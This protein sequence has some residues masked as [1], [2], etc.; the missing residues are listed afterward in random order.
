MPFSFF[1]QRPQSRP[2]EQPDAA[3]KS[4][5]AFEESLQK[6]RSPEQLTRAMRGMERHRTELTERHID[7]IQQRL[8]LLSGSVR[9]TAIEEAERKL[10]E[11]RGH[12]TGAATNA[13]TSNE[14]LPNNTNLGTRIGMG[15]GATVL[16]WF[17][18]RAIRRDG[19][20]GGI[21][22]LFSRNARR[23]TNTVTGSINFARR[24]PIMTALLAGMGVGATVQIREYMNANS[25]ALIREIETSAREQGIDPQRHAETT[26]ERLGNFVRTVGSRTVDTLIQGILSVFGGT[27]DP[28]TGAIHLPHSTLRPPIIIA[29][30][31][32]VRRQGGPAWWRATFGKLGGFLVEP[33]ANAIL[34]E[35]RVAGTMATGQTLGLANEANAL[36]REMNSGASASR[37]VDIEKRLREIHRTLHADGRLGVHPGERFEYGNRNLPQRLEQITA[38]AERLH[39]KEHSDFNRHRH[40]IEQFLRT[41]ENNIRNGNTDGGSVHKYKEAKLGELDTKVKAYEQMLK[42]RKIAVGEEFRRAIEFHAEGRMDR[43]GGGKL[44]SL[45]K[46]M[47]NLGYSFTKLPGA[48][49]VWKGLVGY[50]FLPLGLEAASYFSNKLEGDHRR[51][52]LERKREEGQRLTAA[53]EQELHRLQNQGVTLVKDAAQVGGGFIPVVGEA[54]DFYGAFSGKDLNGRTLSTEARVTMGIMGGLGAAS[55][56]LA[57]FTG[58]LSVVGFRGLRAAIG[59]R[60]AV[61]AVGAVKQVERLRAISTVT[62]TQRTAQS[63]RNLIF[64]A[65]R[66]MQV[67]TYGLLGVQMYSGAVNLLETGSERFVAARERFAGAVE[68][69]TDQI[70]NRIPGRAPR[71]QAPSESGEN[72]SA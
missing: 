46:R 24:N 65:Q 72:E 11:L 19:L 5:K 49:L 4:L 30:Q 18:L 10:D 22:G 34:R 55:L 14:A 50:S 62:N 70:A 52:T 8:T 57:P 27:V 2:S 40:E 51:K 59:T 47:E 44:Y 23:A 31:A 45:T 17:G 13:D 63:A 60:K 15:I 38:E 20:L 42:D 29:W 68:N 71:G 36:Y 39:R 7:L 35:A 69:T 64:T 12:V 25:D 33:K 6:V 43:I 32:G 53:E 41:A 28:E 61:N 56:V 3:E 21:G 37:I 26:G 67:Y 16:G 9:T 66:G 48:K 58:G 54:I 1:P